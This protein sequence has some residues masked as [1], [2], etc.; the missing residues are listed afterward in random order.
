LDNMIYAG[1]FRA[2][3]SLTNEDFTAQANN[4]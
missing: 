1:I 3:V 2:D 4:L